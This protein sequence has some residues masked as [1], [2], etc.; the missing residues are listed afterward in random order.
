MAGMTGDGRLR[1]S[2]GERR[3]GEAVKLAERLAA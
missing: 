3:Q 2:G 1:L